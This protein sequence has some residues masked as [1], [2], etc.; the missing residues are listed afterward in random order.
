MQELADRSDG[1][2]VPVERAGELLEL[3]DAQVVYRDQLTETRLWQ[4]WWL[5]VPLLLMFTLEWS[6]RKHVG[7]S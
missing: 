5:L 7:L 6:I 1:R 4:S 3:L 2:M